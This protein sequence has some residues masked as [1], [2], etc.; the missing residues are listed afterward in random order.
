MTLTQEN[1]PS[2]SLPG[3]SFI[4]ETWT[5]TNLPTNISDII[6][7]Q[8]SKNDKLVLATKKQIWQYQNN[9]TWSAIAFSPN[10]GNISQYLIADTVAYVIVNSLAYEMQL[11]AG[12][13]KVIANSSFVDLATVDSDT[14]WG[15]NEGGYLHKYTP[16]ST[17]IKTEIP[18]LKLWNSNQSVGIAAKGNN[19][20]FGLKYRAKELFDLDKNSI[21]RE[22]VWQIEKDKQTDITENLGL[23][24][25]SGKPFGAFGQLCI[26]PSGVLYAST[27]QGIWQR[28]IDNS[29]NN[30]EWEQLRSQTGNIRLFPLNN[31][32]LLTYNSR[33]QEVLLWNNQTWYSI[34]KPPHEILSAILVG[35]TLYV[36]NNNSLSTISIKTAKSLELPKPRMA[37]YLNL[38]KLSAAIYCQNQLFVSNENTLFTLNP[39]NSE[40]ISLTSLSTTTFDMSNSG[41]NIFIATKTELLKYNIIQNNLTTVFIN[42]TSPTK[43][44][45]DCDRNFTAY[46]ADKV[47]RIF[48][49]S[50]NNLVT[51]ITIK[52][53]F[54]E[55]IVI[56]NNQ[57]Y[58]VGYNNQR[59]TTQKQ[60]VQSAFLRCFQIS[61]TLTQLW[62][63]W[64]FAG[65]ELGN[66]MADTR[67]YRVVA[68]D[69]EVVVLGESAGGNTAF[70]WNG[71]D[72]STPT[73]IAYDIFNDAF[74]S[75]S[76]HFSYYGII[77]ASTGTVKR[78]QF[79]IPRLLPFSSRSNTNRVR[80][81]AYD[82]SNVYVGTLSAF[83]IS[84]RSF[85]KFLGKKP[86]V[87][88]D[89]DA[90]LL[91]VSSDLASRDFWFTPGNGQVLCF[92]ENCVVINVAADTPQNPLLNGKGRVNGED[93]YVI[94]W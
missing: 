67:M 9:G 80:S 19:F 56:K 12:Q 21:A 70:R 57:L 94:I 33:S 16:G 31:S 93:G 83:Q 54:V 50:T 76:A 8:V 22:T 77:D 84:D 45:I 91:K 58:V 63:T 64:G 35:D 79:S 7:V 78:G 68:S 46:L 65:N 92:D 5:K 18:A 25:L 55:D 6:S 27:E 51:Q 38:G 60:P 30:L 28:S 20:W 62:Q 10:A 14:L 52:A 90:T 44:R 39:N 49:N 23:L 72:L 37:T 13:W 74:D 29:G 59:N 36:A 34:P 53:D 61:N 82:E 66:D 32:S 88:K 11:E 17:W 87:Y 75:K 81:L 4:K 40:P 1:P 73:L 69:R 48:D 3:L 15:I 85:T 41:E 24:N 2:A 47:I 89:G 86:P 42:P 71:K 26:T 43:A